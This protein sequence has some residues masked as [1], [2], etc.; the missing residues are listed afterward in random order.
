M[1][2]DAVASTG[3]YAGLWGHLKSIDH[4]LG[5]VL[6]PGD[7]RRL[8]AL[9]KDRLQAL[10]GIL[11]GSLTKYPDLADDD[12]FLR[13]QPFEPDYSVAMDFYEKISDHQDFKAWRKSAR[14]SS[15]DKIKRLVKALND[16]LSEDNR[17]LFGRKDSRKQEI[18]VLRA[19]L[20]PLLAE[21]EAALY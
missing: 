19:V 2:Q 18:E 9:D 6:V 21:T 17:G 14:E 11:E 10:I 20:K 5:R 8:T 16:I 4:A 7:P 3:P 15:G 12:A 13:C 1:M